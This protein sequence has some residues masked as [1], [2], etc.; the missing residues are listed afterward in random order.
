M[1]PLIPLML[2]ALAA[3]AL[4]QTPS[5]AHPR[6]KDLQVVDDATPPKE[7][8]PPPPRVQNDPSDTKVTIRKEGDKTI[9]EYRLK[10]R[11]YKMR[12]VPAD[13]KP[14]FLVDDKGE[15]KFM[16]VDG[17]EPKI[18]VPMWVLIEW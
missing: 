12:I 16:R 7:P 9:E 11:L 4:A 15:G 8:A 17:P 3:P 13:G 5:Q 1:R 2:I 6:P 10:G 18:A 14:Y